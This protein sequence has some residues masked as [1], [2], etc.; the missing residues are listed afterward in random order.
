VELSTPWL[1]ASVL[2][3]AIGF[4][5]LHYGRKLGRPPHAVIGLSMMVY[6]YFIPSVLPMALVGAALLLVLGLAVRLGW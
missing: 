6:P 2:A 1:F 4:V 3:S 5:L